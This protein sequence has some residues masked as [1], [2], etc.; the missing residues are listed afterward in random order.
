MSKI[1]VEPKRGRGGLPWWVWV[2]IVLVII[3]LIWWLL[4]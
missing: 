1:P 3:V 4:L 2:L